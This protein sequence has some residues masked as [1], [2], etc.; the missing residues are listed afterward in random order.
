MAVPRSLD[1]TWGHN[2]TIPITERLIL[3]TYMTKRDTFRV[4]RQAP[5][6]RK[7]PMRLSNSLCTA[8]PSPSRALRLQHALL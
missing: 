1:N 7:A 6:V 8:P 2:I 5:R 3:T 4:T